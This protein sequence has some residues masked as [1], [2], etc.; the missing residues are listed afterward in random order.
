MPRTFLDSIENMS[1]GMSFMFGYFLASFSIASRIG[2]GFGIFLL[3]FGGVSAYGVIAA[4]GTEQS[5]NRYAEISAGTLGAQQIARAGE[6]G[7]GFAVV[8]S[9]VKNLAGQTA[10]ATEEIGAAVELGG[11]SSTLNEEVRRFIGEVRTL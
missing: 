10:K 3:L 5:V 7:R 1:Q 11:K 8:A 2:A 4:N 9:E 6:A